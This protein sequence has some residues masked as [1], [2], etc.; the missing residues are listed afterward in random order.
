MK[1]EEEEERGG[2][3][4]DINNENMNPTSPSKEEQVC[5]HSEKLAIVYGLM[6]TPANT[7]L[8]IV[9]NLRVCGD[10]HTASRMISKIRQREI[11]LRDSNRFHHIKDGQCSCQHDYIIDVTS[12]IY[13]CALVTFSL[14]STK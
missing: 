12:R 1:E 13:L 5:R 3:G 8:V 14:G 4:N 7:Q 6:K 11:V 2:R 10:C 9:K